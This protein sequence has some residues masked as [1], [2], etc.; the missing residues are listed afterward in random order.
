MSKPSPEAVLKKYGSLEVWEWFEEGVRKIELTGEGC[1]S[2]SA[3]N[4]LSGDFIG[5]DHYE[6]ILQEDA[7]VYLPRD[8]DLLSMFA[9]ETS[10]EDRLLASFRKGVISTTANVAPREMVEMVRAFRSGD[11]DRARALHYRLLPLI[12]ALFCETNPI[13]LKAAM[14]LRGLTTDEIRLPLTPL[15]EQNRELLQVTRKECGLL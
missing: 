13:P 12:D 10:E 14:A 8:D 15:S 5:E 4:S 7:D 1:L 3:S 9:D 6:I 2:D 11:L